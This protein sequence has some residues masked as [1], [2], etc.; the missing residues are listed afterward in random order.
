MIEE[1]KTSL[2]VIDEI[3]SLAYWLTGS[4]KDASNLLRNTYLGSEKNSSVFELIKKF[5]LCYYDS[6]GLVP[7]SGFMETFDQPK[8][9]LTQSMWKWYEDIKLTVLLSEIPGLKHCDIGEIT[10][11]TLETTRLWLFLGRKQLINE[12]LMH[13]FSLSREKRFKQMH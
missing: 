6:I 10:G 3:Y 5:R 11:N 4:K 13:Y 1:K 8:E 7:V 12:T 9:Q 2:D